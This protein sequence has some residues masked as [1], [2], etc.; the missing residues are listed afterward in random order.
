MSLTPAPFHDDV[1]DG[2]EG[3]AYW[4]TAEDG[5]RVRVGVWG[6]GT[7]GTVLLFPGRTEYIEKYGRAASD[8]LAHGYSTVAIDWRGQ[9]LADRLQDNPN[10]GHVGAFTDYQKDLRAVLALLPELDLPEP[11]HLLGH[12]MGGCIGLRALMEGLSVKSAAFTAPMWGISLTKPKRTAAWVVSTIADTVGMDKGLAPGTFEKT[13]VLANPFDDN[14]LTNDPE[15]FDYM[16]DQVTAHPELA[17]GGPSL[18]WLGEGLRECRSLRLRPTPQ[19]PTLTFLGTDERI[20][21]VEA[22]T[23]RM[24]RWSNGT[25]EMVDGAEHEVLMEVAV[26]RNNAVAQIVRHFDAHQ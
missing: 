4:V 16:K 17:I 18:A 21:D 25:L 6:G 24:A 12:S 9:G 26:S 23:D 5:I 15:M 10:I 11:M 13:Y 1:A 3:A 22:I 20:V 14:M 8:F 7:K 19:V 2:P